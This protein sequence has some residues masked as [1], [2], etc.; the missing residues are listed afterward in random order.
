MTDIS[1]IPN[2]VIDTEEQTALRKVAFDL[3]SRYGIEYMRSKSD[4]GET[5]DELWTEAGKLGLLGVNL[6][7]QRTATAC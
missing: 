7:V 1:Q 6:K 4:A 5:T 3:G 2:P